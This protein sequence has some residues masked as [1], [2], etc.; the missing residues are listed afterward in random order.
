MIR[1]GRQYKNLNLR[2]DVGGKLNISRPRF[3]SDFYL[4]KYLLEKSGWIFTKIDYFKSLSLPSLEERKKNYLKSKDLAGVFVLRKLDYFN[5]IYGFKYNQVRIKNQRNCWGS[6]SGKKN[7]NFNWK[8]INLPEPLVDLIVVHELCHLAEMNH[9][10]NFWRL[11]EKAIPDYK[12]RR[13]ELKKI[14]HLTL[15]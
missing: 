2:V 11:V 10:N 9:S 14:N 6:C 13:Q 15:G 7:L 1:T 3:L 4:N 8:V 12:K 5:Q